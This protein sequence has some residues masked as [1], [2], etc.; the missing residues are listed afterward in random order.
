LTWDN[1]TKSEFACNCG[2][3]INAI[4][5]SHIDVLQE[6]RTESGVMMIITSGYRCALHPEEFEKSKPGE[7]NDGTASDVAVSHLAAWKVLKAAMA[8]PK[9]TGIGV[10]QKGH[11]RFLHISTGGAKPGRPRPH[12]WSY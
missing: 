5:D 8:N 9:V 7:H 1:F 6:I 12:I 10:Q 2:C 11:G 3:G 4:Q